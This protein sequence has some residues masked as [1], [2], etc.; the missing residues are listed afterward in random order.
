MEHFSAVQVLPPKLF[1]LQPSSLF[2]KFAECFIKLSID[3][4]GFFEEQPQVMKR[5]LRVLL[6]D[7]GFLACNV[8]LHYTLCTV[9]VDGT[10]EENIRP[11][12]LEFRQLL[13]SVLFIISMASTQSCQA[14]CHLECTEFQCQINHLFFSGQCSSENIT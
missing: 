4:A 6:R 5:L 9:E 12:S 14:P 10:A 11:F 3:F 8:I 2:P 7:K 13:N 1:C